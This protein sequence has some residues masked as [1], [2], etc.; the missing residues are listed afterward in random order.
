LDYYDNFFKDKLQRNPTDVECFDMGQSNPGT[1][2]LLVLLRKLIIN[3][4]PKTQ[5]LFQMVKA[6]LP[7]T[8]GDNSLIAFHDNSST[9]RSYKYPKVPRP[10]SHVSVGKVKLGEQTLHPILTA[11]THNFPCGV[12]PFA[13]AETGTGG[14]LRD[15][16]ATGRGA[17]PIAGISAYCVGNLQIPEYSLPW[18]E[19][20]FTYPSNLA[21]PLEIQL[22]ANDGPSD[23]GNKYGEPVICGWFK[24]CFRLSCIIRRCFGGWRISICFDI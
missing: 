13:G 18:E 24:W 20:N 8:P 11:E 1:S 23:Y 16:M 19:S 5:T 14:R 2:P 4:T 9:I 15:G 21:R 10:T 3:G 6:T 22:R 17:Y 12:A 7:S